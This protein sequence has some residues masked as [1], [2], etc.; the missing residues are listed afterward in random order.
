[1]THKNELEHFKVDFSFNLSLDF[2]D[3]VKCVNAFHLMIPNES[4]P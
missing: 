1:M 3:T 4:M 2:A